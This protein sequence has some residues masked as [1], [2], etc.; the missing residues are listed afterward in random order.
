MEG[1]EY[2]NR[3]QREAE[4]EVSILIAPMQVHGKRGRPGCVPPCTYLQ[5]RP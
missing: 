1:E 3:K 4:K 5:D 2:M